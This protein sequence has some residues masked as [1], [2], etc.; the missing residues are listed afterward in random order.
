MNMKKMISLLL[1]AMCLFSLAACSSK[2]PVS[3][4]SVENEME[5]SMEDLQIANPFVNYDSIDE[6][7]EVT[8]FDFLV[9]A[10]MDGYTDRNVQV[11]DGKMIQV[12]FLDESGNMLI[13]RKA[14]GSE[15]ISGDY[16]IYADT[17]TVTL[18]NGAEAELRGDETSF[19]GAVWT[20]DGFTYAVS[21][22]LPME[23]AAMV[24]LISTLDLAD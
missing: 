20:A 15:D 22:D 24:D 6:A 21:S 11:V 12:T 4:G 2:A 3:E 13:L 14:A 8:G 10:S 7:A 18:P 9:P 16:I 5:G 23:E 17:K 19:Q 1:C